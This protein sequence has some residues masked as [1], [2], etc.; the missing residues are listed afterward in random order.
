V[1]RGPL[2]DLVSWAAEG[3]RGEVTV[4]VEG[5]P[6]ATEVDHDPDS[7]RAAVA[8]EEAAGATRKEAIADVARR[9]GLPKR[10]VYAAVH[11]A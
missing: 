11:L 2:A 7:L 1:R 6:P 3:V 9:A 4:V 8:D 10:E 5:A